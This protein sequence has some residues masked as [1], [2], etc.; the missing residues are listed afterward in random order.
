MTTLRTGVLNNKLDEENLIPI[1]SNNYW[2]VSWHEDFK[3]IIASLIAHNIYVEGWSGTGKTFP[4]EQIC[5][6]LGRELIRVQITAETDED[7][8]LGGLRLVDGNTQFELGPCAQAA[9]RGAVLLLDEV[10]LASPK[11]MCLQPLLEHQAVIIKKVGKLVRPKPGF[12]V[13]ATANTKGMSDETGRYVGTN[14]MNEA[15]LERF[16]I[17]VHADFPPDRVEM[18]ILMT[19]LTNLKYTPKEDADTVETLT[20]RWVAWANQSRAAVAA[21][22]NEA[23]LSTRRLIFMARSFVIFDGDEL[24]AAEYTVNRFPLIEQ[25]A[26]ME[27][28]KKLIPSK[29]D[30]EAAAPTPS[31]SSEDEKRME[32]LR[33]PSKLVPGPNGQKTP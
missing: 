15:F 22:S 24:K 33:S 32:I 2:P 14:P 7:D 6:E 26:L 19:E 10:D 29:S 27:T 18:K 21:Q 23:L 31:L 4:I 1:K 20:Q 28:L 5:A 30:E 16:P 3:R 13:V 8:L 17:M 9:E 25:N 11:I 12:I